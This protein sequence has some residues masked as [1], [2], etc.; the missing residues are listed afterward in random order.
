MTENTSVVASPERVEGEEPRLADALAEFDAMIA[1]QERSAVARRQL[2]ETESLPAVRAQRA[3]HG[4]PAVRA[5]PADPQHGA[6]HRSILAVEERRL[7][8]LKT[9][10]SALRTVEHERDELSDGY[11]DAENENERLRAEVSALRA[12]VAGLEKD[13][14]ADTARLDWL[15]Y[16]KNIDR[17]GIEPRQRIYGGRIYVEQDDGPD[18][19]A[20]TVRDAIDSILVLAS[21][22]Q[23]ATPTENGHE[24]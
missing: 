3:Q 16:D 5:M 13:K 24:R 17:I 8:A 6:R 12:Q 19:H 22:P 20:E 4:R 2:A 7:E 1:E 23:S 11:T 9:I 10:R 18:L 14:A 15:E 21:H